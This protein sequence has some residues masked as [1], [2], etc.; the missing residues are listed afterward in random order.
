[1]HD[2]PGRGGGR[3]SDFWVGIVSTSFSV[4]S[5]TGLTLARL[6]G[7]GQI[8]PSRGSEFPFAPSKPTA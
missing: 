1:V 3:V 2:T 4:G 6:A 5:T 8:Q 7:E